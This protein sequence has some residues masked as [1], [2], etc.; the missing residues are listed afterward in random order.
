MHTQEICKTLL[1]SPCTSLSGG[2]LSHPSL[3][4]F[5][6]SL[7]LYTSFL[8]AASHPVP[9]LRDWPHE[10]DVW[11]Q[12]DPERN[13]GVRGCTPSMMYFVSSSLWSS[14]INIVRLCTYSNFRGSMS[15][16]TAC[17]TTGQSTPSEALQRSLTISNH[18]CRHPVCQ[19]TNIRCSLQECALLHPRSHRNM[20]PS[21]KIGSN[22]KAGG[23]HLII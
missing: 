10:T 4:W 17:K 19:Q 23:W 8:G 7:R 3:K 12:E 6:R 15:S 11:I 18:Y 22:V 14:P 2:C 1:N 21:N 20:N 16:H 13:E 9:S 5:L